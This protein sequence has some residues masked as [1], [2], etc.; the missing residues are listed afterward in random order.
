[1]THRTEQCC[2]E[3]SGWEP[4]L[5][6]CSCQCHYSP[7]DESVVSPT[8]PERV[9][10]FS[11]GFD[12]TWN[13]AVAILLRFIKG[14]ISEEERNAQLKVLDDAEKLRLT[15]A[16]TETDQQAREERIICS[17]V[18]YKGK[19]WMGHRHGNALGAMHDELSYTMNRREM[20]AEQ[21]DREQGFVTSTGRYVD[22]AEGWNIAEKA[23]QILKRDYQKE[24]ELYSEDLW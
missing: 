11:K 14:E 3:C 19:V 2:K 13:S 4:A 1:M 21:T 5:H 20:T 12:A 18:R 24:G 23:G 10:E 8:I 9:E 7:T 17:A 16:L 15:T 6:E 22:R